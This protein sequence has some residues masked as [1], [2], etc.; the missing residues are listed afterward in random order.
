[1]LMYAI[2]KYM[3]AFTIKVNEVDNLMPSSTKNKWKFLFYQSLDTYYKI[4]DR[5]LKNE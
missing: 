3:A 1:M 4:F 2:H 5:L